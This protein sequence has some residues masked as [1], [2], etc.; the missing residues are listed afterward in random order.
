MTLLEKLRTIGRGWIAEPDIKQTPKQKSVLGGYV[1]LFQNNALVTNT[2]AS[3]KLLGANTGWVYRNN[4]VIAKE[5]ANIEFELF[6][7]RVVGK[8]IIFDPILQHPILDSLDRFNEFTAASDGF[9]LTQSHRKLTGDAFWYVDGQNTQVNGIYLLQPDKVTLELGKPVAGQ[10]IINKYVYEDNVN[11]D[12]IKETYDADE[13]VHFKI[14]NPNN[15]YRGKSA[16]EAAAESIDTDNYAVEAN[17]GLFKRGLITNFV[18]STENKLT[19]EQLSQLRAELRANYGGAANA[20]KAMILSGGLKPETIQMSNKDVEFIKQ[21]EW[22][23]DKIMSIFGNNRAVLGITDDVN[24]ANAEATIL[25]W[26]RTTVK[27]EMKAIT[28]TLNEFFVPRFGTNL[29]IGFK[30]PVPED[31]EGKISESTQLVDKK[32]ITQN[33]ARELL[34]YDPIKDPD[35]DLLNKPVPE[36][37]APQVPKSIQNVNYTKV[38]RKLGVY[39]KVVQAE[40]LKEAAIP[41][42]KKII[43]ARTKKEAP[44]EVREHPTFTNDKVWGFHRKQIHIVEAQEEIFREKVER[45]INR[46]VERAIDQVPD[47]IALIQKK[48][49]FDEEGLVTQ[50]TVD[51][52]PILNEVLILSGQQA[53][54]FID[55]DDLYLA[56]DVRKVIEENVRKFAKSMLETDRD[57]IV[58]IIADGLSGGDSVNRIRNN[59][60]DTFD[61]FSKVQAERI[62]RTEVIRASNIGAEDAWRQ[63]GVV[64]G[65]QWL[66][67]LDDR[68]DPLCE[69]MNGKIVSLSKSYFRKGEVLEVN[70]HKADFSYGAVKEPPLHP[71]C[72]CTLLPVLVGQNGFDADTFL[73]IS[74]LENDKQLLESKIDKRTK[75]YK[76]LKAKNLELENYVKE[77]EEIVGEEDLESQ[78]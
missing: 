17:K 53:L 32:I 39:E 69:Y 48:A 76:N 70:G 37:V 16:V 18:L 74:G 11:G 36:T 14:P 30:D 57:K 33:E 26:K 75:A 31:R 72:R 34:G 29:I 24:R 44:V 73:K 61:E 23:R 45:F 13:I 20:Y 4:D 59:I 6:T 77:L 78:E 68:V 60:V 56:F 55:S 2:K 8:E 15:P 54:K 27:S 41:I 71:N 46:V 65:K 66:T 9:Y 63:S 40:K 62:T 43:G 64:T 7:T 49:L 58:E 51:F 22:L 3:D 10:K 52:T 19:N 21:Q 28:D 25:A 50:A 67:A 47:E 1:D 5:V 35:A 38:L 42:A 12:K